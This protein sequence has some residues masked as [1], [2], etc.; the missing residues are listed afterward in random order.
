[1]KDNTQNIRIATAQFETK[2]GAKD[3][4]LSVVR[5]LSQKAKQQ[6]ANV[7]CFHEMCITGYTFLKDLSAEQCLALAEDLLDGPS[8]KELIQIARECE[9]VVLAGLLEKEDD[10]LY[11][12]F[13][14]VKGSGIIAKHRKIH[15]FINSC[16]SAGDE[17]TVF[18]VNGWNCGILIC[19]DNNIIENV[20]ATALMD[21]Q[22]IF[23]PHVTMCAPSPFPGSGYVNKE[24]WNKKT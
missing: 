11:N 21:A 23:A 17:Y 1:M 22:I 19:Y 8:V 20:R 15:P 24:L 16:L 6:K 9:I 13:I 2:S 12:T 4:N 14:C 3:Y 10:R 5:K 7:V 18:E